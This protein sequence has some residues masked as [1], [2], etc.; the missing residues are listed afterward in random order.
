MSLGTIFETE[1]YCFKQQMREVLLLANMYQKR[2]SLWLT[3][4]GCCI[5]QKKNLSDKMQEYNLKLSD[6]QHKKGK[7]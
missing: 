6:F 7:K 1:I 5:M 3:F 2:K 4:L